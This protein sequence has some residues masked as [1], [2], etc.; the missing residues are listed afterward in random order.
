M[1]KRIVL[2]SVLLS[3]GLFGVSA[4]LFF[5]E[6]TSAFPELKSGSYVGSL[7]FQ[8]GTSRTIP[9]AI[10]IDKEETEVFIGDEDFPALRLPAP[11]V[12]GQNLPFTISGNS[13][14]L[15][16]IGKLHSNGAASGTFL[17]SINGEEGTWTLF[18]NT[19]SPLSSS[20]AADLQ[21][22]GVV[23]AELQINTAKRVA[24]EAK[25]SQQR[26]KINK[27]SQIVGS[28]GALQQ[29]GT[30]RLGEATGAVASAKSDITDLQEKI[31]TV[32]RDIALA[33]DLSPRGRLVSL[34]RESIEREARWIEGSLQLVTP[35]SIP[36]F[37]QAFERA[38]RVK[39]LKDQIEQE[40]ERIASI[41]STDRYRG[42]KIETP[43]EEEFYRKL[44]ESH[45]TAGE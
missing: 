32:A 33:R 21:R 37:N 43:N 18:S 25:V 1:I 23:W 8:G 16:L 7:D 34:S 26:S 20:E 36:D 2:C 27:L 9:W 41:E 44:Q 15:R 19:N 13:I 40:R 31:N 24:L 4:Y 38:L 30:S 35:D 45:E 39:E 12:N 5:S 42:E 3:I 29:E 6:V 10:R 28:G 14:R 11:R 17:N 22:W